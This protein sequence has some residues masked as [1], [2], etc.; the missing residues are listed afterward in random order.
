MGSITEKLRPAPYEPAVK[1]P[2]PCPENTEFPLSLSAAEPD[3][4]IAD[5]VAQIQSLSSSGELHS[6]LDKHG[7]VYFQKLGLRNAEEFSQFAHAFGWT[8][9]EDIGNPVR[10][11]VHA[12]NVATA[13]E[14]P[15]TQPVYPHN[16]F[17]L[18][19]H[20][21]AYV[22]FYCA[23]PP[24]TG[25]FHGAVYKDI[26]D[27]DILK[28]VKYQLFYPNGP[29]DQQSSAGTTVLQAYGR[30]LIDTDDTETPRSKIEAEVKRLPT[31]QWVWENKS[32]NNPLGDLR[33]WQ[34]LPVASILSGTTLAR[35]TLRSS[36]TPICLRWHIT[37][38]T[39]NI[40]P[41]N[42]TVSRFLNAVDSGTLDPPHLNKDAKYQPPAF[43]GGGSLIPRKYFESAV[44]II[45]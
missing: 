37:R 8:A 7:A 39:P 42:R 38:L 32:D 22:L 34:H 26:P 28:G 29:R 19:P 30:T 6:V 4:H 35:E 21:P 16:E 9:H 44:E 23:S 27:N 40:C 24:E 13:N 11:T 5:Q 43:Y 12:E 3:T 1:L 17:G 15:N 20:Y 2:A 18:S 33:V 14:G 36:T 45:K 31:A 10:R 41:N 25:E